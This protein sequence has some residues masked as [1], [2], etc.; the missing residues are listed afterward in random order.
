[1][2]QGD[3]FSPL[4]LLTGEDLLDCVTSGVVKATHGIMVLYHN[5]DS[6]SGH[7][8]DTVVFME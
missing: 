3:T 2:S 6:F 4:F 7:V 1:M 5:A 8:Q